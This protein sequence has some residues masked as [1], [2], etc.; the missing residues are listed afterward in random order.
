MVE[1]VEHVVDDLG[2]TVIADLVHT[3]HSGGGDVLVRYSVAAIPDIR[4]RRRSRTRR[5]RRGRRRAR[6]D[7]E[8][9][10]VTNLERS[11]S[12]DGD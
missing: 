11:R 7:V 6:E 3:I 2:D 4:T 5:Y 12:R 8:E 1:N 9:V 10:D